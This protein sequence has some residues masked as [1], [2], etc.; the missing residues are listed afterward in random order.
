MARIKSG[1]T[2]YTRAT[3]DINF[4]EDHV[5]CALCPLMQ[6]YSRKQCMRTG[7]LIADDRGIGYYCPLVF[8][9]KEKDNV[10]V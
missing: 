3:V 9:D 10:Q 4:P 2:F 8:E 5:C 7:E 6:T 1:I